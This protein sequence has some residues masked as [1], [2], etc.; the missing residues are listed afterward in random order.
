[1]QHL[2][3]EIYNTWVMFARFIADIAGLYWYQKH[4]RPLTH[5]AGYV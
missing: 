5:L 3:P 2:M 4:S 1:M